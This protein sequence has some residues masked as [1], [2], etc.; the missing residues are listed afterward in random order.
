VTRQRTLFPDPEPERHG[1]ISEPLDPNVIYGP[2]EDDYDESFWKLTDP[3]DITFSDIPPP[4][5]APEDLPFGIA[6]YVQELYENY[7]PR[8]GETLAMRRVYRIAND[9]QQIEV[10]HG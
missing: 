1:P 9:Y 6:A 2:L 4:E 8:I 3:P 5:P 10:R 7:R